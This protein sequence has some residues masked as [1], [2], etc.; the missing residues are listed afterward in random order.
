MVFAPALSSVPGKVMR[1]SENAPLI[2]SRRVLLLLDEVGTKPVLT[3]LLGVAV[4]PDIGP[5][6]PPRLVPFTAMISAV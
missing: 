6:L 5:E 1:S 4:T 3:R 2:P